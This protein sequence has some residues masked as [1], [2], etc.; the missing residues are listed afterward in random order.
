MNW[1]DVTCDADRRKI[2]PYYLW[3]WRMKNRFLKLLMPF[4]PK[5]TCDQM[6]LWVP[7]IGSLSIG[8]ACWRTQFFEEIL[9]S[10][11][12]VRLIWYP[13]GH[14]G[15]QTLV[16]SGLNSLDSMLLPTESKSEMIGHSVRDENDRQY[17]L[18]L[19]W[20]LI[21]LYS[22]TVQCCVWAG[23]TPLP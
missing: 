19:D 1:H 6:T 14:P 15:S 18:H 11:W 5:G 8:V 4:N 16:A 2:R 22:S 23:T 3:T 7:W 21:T 17:S 10:E 13:F 20:Y 9:P 12:H